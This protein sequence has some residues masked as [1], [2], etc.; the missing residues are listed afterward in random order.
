MPKM[1]IRKDG[2][3]TVHKTPKVSQ[4]TPISKNGVNRYTNDDSYPVFR[5][6]WKS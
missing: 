1:S 4:Q 5:K 2:R 3:T 6:K